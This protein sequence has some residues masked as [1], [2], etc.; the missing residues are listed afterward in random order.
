MLLYSKG[1]KTAEL[2]TV[3]L[4]L[5]QKHNGGLEGNSFSLLSQET[6][7]PKHCTGFWAEVL[8]ITWFEP[9]RIYFSTFRF[10]P[11]KDL[12]HDDVNN[13]TTA[14]DIR[15]KDTYIKST[16][17]FSHDSFEEEHFLSYTLI[18]KLNDIMCVHL[19]VCTI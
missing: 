16:L 9:T 14:D 15:I 11:I 8:I 3:R 18:I 4:P 2:K 1:E 6:V 10:L 7:K 13:E 5:K 19:S 12:L 17:G